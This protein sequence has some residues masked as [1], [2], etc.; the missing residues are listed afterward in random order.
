[1]SVIFGHFRCVRVGGWM[2]EF[3]VLAIASIF[4]LATLYLLVMTF[5]YSVVGSMSVS[6]G[7]CL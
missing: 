1:M 7:T 3:E 5:L 2:N 4:A 6:P